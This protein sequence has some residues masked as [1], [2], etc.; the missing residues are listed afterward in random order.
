V[1]LTAVLVSVAELDCVP[2]WVS[3]LDGV[4]EPVLDTDALAVRDCRGCNT[5][6]AC[7][8]FTII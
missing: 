4:H 8:A 7:S 5:A 2:L 1:T 6:S 3:V